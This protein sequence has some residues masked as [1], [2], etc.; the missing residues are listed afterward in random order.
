MSLTISDS[1]IIGSMFCRTEISHACG[2]LFQDDVDDTASSPGP[3]PGVN[4]TP[5]NQTHETPE[6]L[7]TS[8][9]ET[10]KTLLTSTPSPEV[11]NNSAI[12]ELY[13]F[14]RDTESDD[15]CIILF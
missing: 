4:Q 3:S 12:K 8:T 14:W 13:N 10:P 5:P 11:I 7:L 6:T 9:H 15:P 1:S 2:V